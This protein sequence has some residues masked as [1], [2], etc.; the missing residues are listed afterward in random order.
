M[1]KALYIDREALDV[2]S[3]GDS[4]K[5]VDAYFVAYLCPPNKQYSEPWEW[6]VRFEVARGNKFLMRDFPDQTAAI[7]ERGYT[8]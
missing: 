5:R 8:I 4:R 2:R 3:S 6:V 1:I 7:S